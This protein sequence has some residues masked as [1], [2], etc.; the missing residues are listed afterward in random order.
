MKLVY[1]LGFLTAKA[2]RWSFTILF[3]LALILMACLQVLDGPLVTRAAPMGIISFELAGDLGLAR[4]MVDSWGPEGRVYA[5]LSLGLDYL[6][7][8]VY[9]MAIILGCML[10]SKGLLKRLPL[11]AFLGAILAWGQI[12]A[13]LLDALENYALI[14]ILLGT[15]E[16]IWA[17][18][19]RWA[20]LPK[21]AIVFLGIVYILLGAIAN[22]AIKPKTVGN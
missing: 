15:N 22:L 1:P 17:L 19:A 21:F 4:Q 18:V 12:G 3:L 2:Q 14:L 13:A 8:V 11:L 10:V 5:G 20:A 7:M 9:A 16:E 6:F